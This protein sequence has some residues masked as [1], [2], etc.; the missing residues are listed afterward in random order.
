MQ[1]TINTMIEDDN[2]YYIEVYNDHDVEN[3]LKRESLLKMKKGEQTIKDPYF[4][5]KTWWK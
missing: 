4:S 2:S 1:E 5:W 3:N